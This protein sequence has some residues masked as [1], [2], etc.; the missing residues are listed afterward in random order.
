M[1]YGYARPRGITWTVAGTGASIA[2]D[3]RL[4]NGQP[5]EATAIQW[6]TAPS[7]ALADYVDLRAEWAA[8]SPIRVIPLVGLS[9][10]AGVKVQV[11]GLRSGDDAFTYA[12]GGN[13]ATGRT[14]ALPDGRVV[15]FVVC[16]AGLDPLIGIQVRIFNDRS[17][18][19]WATATTDLRIGEAA[20]FSA[21]TLKGKPGWRRGRTDPSQRQR[22][23]AGGLHVAPM[24]AWR[25]LDVDIP[26]ADVAA[27]RAGGLENGQ[28]WETLEAATA[29]DARAICIVHPDSD[30][31]IHRTA[32]YGWP[33][34]D[35]IS[36]IPQ[37]R[38]LYGTRLTVEEVI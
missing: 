14:V 6:L 21:V 30:A 35:T 13:S 33:K 4:D 34:F 18:A 36:H 9:C 23:R 11:T 7:P 31:E 3:I 32:I 2:S 19:T 17:G 37:S 25:I 28:D 20:P 12:L 29:G 26:P 38:G 15:L 1:I 22:T 10:G 5:S 24:D 27:V 8:A 16:A